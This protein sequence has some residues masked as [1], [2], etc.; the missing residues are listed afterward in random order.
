MIPEPRDLLTQAA[1]EVREREETRAGEGITRSLRRHPGL[2]ECQRRALRWA[3]EQDSCKCHPGVA[4]VL[5]RKGLVTVHRAV[6]GGTEIEPTTA[7]KEVVA[8]MGE[9]R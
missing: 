9:T 7:G 5:A 8:A 6:G 2:N 3:V 1:R 4:R